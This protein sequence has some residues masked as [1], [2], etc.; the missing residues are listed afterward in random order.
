[1]V[2]TVTPEPEDATK[3]LNVERFQGGVEPCGLLRRHHKGLKVPV[4]TH[5]TT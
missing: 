5:L 2:V 4:R 3:I 1:M